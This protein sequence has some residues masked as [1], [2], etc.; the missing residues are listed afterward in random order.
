MFKPNS[1]YTAKFALRV[2]QVFNSLSTIKFKVLHHLDKFW[3]FLYKFVDAPDDFL[4]Q[5][6]KDVGS[7]LSSFSEGN[8][9]NF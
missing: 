5:I 6:Q 7:L 1:V 4:W 9:T 2:C 3:F 8:L